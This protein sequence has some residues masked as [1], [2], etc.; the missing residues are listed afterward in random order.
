MNPAPA[1]H[2]SGRPD[3]C[4]STTVTVTKGPIKIRLGRAQRLGSGRNN[5]RGT[6]WGVRAEGLPFPRRP[7]SWS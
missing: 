7:P 5:G 4:Y 6:A 2:T 1:A 3:A